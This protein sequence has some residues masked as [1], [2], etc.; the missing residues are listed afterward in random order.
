MP[1]QADDAN[2]FLPK[3][4]RKIE[5]AAGISRDFPF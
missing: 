5:V 2:H 4:Q 1:Q 3:K